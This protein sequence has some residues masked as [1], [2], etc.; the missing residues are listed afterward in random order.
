M[1]GVRSDGSPA[2]D[3]CLSRKWRIK[4]IGVEELGLSSDR[5]AP[6]THLLFKKPAMCWELLSVSGIY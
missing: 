6:K 3:K 5:V 4:I 1:K 2:S